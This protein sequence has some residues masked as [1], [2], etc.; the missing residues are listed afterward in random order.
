MN[1]TL[2]QMIVNIGYLNTQICLMNDGNKIYEQ[3]LIVGGM[4]MDISIVQAFLDRTGKKIDTSLAQAIRIDSWAGM[5]L[6]E[7]FVRHQFEFEATGEI[8]ASSLYGID[9]YSCIA[10]ANHQIAESVFL[11]LRRASSI[12]TISM[13]IELHLCGTDVSPG[14]SALL[15]EKTGLPVIFDE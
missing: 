14:L 4:F 9:V 10:D 12:E 1:S 7:V 5:S 15:Q 2:G 11:A 6:G 13:Q 8:D 3:H